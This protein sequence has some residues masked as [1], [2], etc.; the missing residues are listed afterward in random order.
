[1]KTLLLGLLLCFPFLLN[2]QTL[3]APVLISPAHLATNQPSTLTLKWYSVTGA[4][5]YMVEVIKSG[6]NTPFISDTAWTDTTRLLTNLSGGMHYWRIKAKRLNPYQTSEWSAYRVF[7]VASTGGQTLATPVLVSPSSGSNFQVKGTKLSWKTV[8]GATFYKVKVATDAAMNNLVFADSNV[9]VTSRVIPNLNF[10]TT[11]YWNVRAANATSQSA[12]SAT[13]SLTTRPD[14]P[15][16]V[17]THPRLWFTQADLPRLRGWAVAGNPIY[18]A[19]KTALTSANNTYTTKFY[20]GGQANPNWPD[21]GGVTWPAY[22]TEA[23]AEFFAFNSLID[24]NPANRILYAQRA[25]NLLMYIIDAAILGPALGVPFRDPYFANKDRMN[26]WGETYALTVDWIYDAKDANNNPILTAEDK[27]K[28]RTVFMRWCSEQLN[29]YNHPTPIGIMND[30]QLL[31]DRHALNNYYSGHSRSLIMLSLALDPS[32]DPVLD[33]VLPEDALGNSLRSY[34]FNAT[35]AWLYQQYSQYELASIVAND[36]GISPNYPDLS[37]GSG[38][39]SVE[40]S[41]YGGSIGAVSGGLLA[42]KTAGWSNPAVVGPQAKLITSDYWKRYMNGMMHSA[43]PVGKVNQGAAW[44]GPIYPLAC[45]GESIRTWSTPNLIHAMGTTGLLAEI[46]GDQNQL[47]KARWYARNIIEGSAEKLTSRVSGI[48][49]NNAASH[50]ILYYLLLNPSGSNPADPRPTIATTFVDPARPRVLARTDWSANATWFDWQCP[51]ITLDHQLGDA[52]QFELYRKGEWLIK[53]RSGYGNDQLAYTSEFHNT[54]ALQNDVPANLAWFETVT[55]QRGGQ[56]ILGQNAG[57]PSSITSVG[58]NFVY[59]TG[60]ATSLY[61]RPQSSP[62]NSATD[63][64]YAVR[65]IVWLKP[66]HVI[67]YDRAKSKTANRFK[68]FFLQ[69]TA[70]PVIS[71]KNATVSTPGGQKLYLSNLLPAGSVLTTSVSED[72]NAVSALDPTHDEIKIEDTSN[73]T[74]VRFLNVIQGADGGTAKDVP[75]LVQSTDGTLFEGA[76]VKNL[77]VMFPNLWGAPFTF[78]TYTIPGTVNGQIVT[79]LTPNA[80]YNVSTTPN[81]SNVSV[82]ITPGGQLMADA[83]GVLLIGNTNLGLVAAPHNSPIAAELALRTSPNPF[84]E[85]MTIQYELP[86]ASQVS[87]RVLDI[88]GNTVAVLAKNE[89]QAAGQQALL[90]S[91]YNLPAG[92]Y[93]CE[94]TAGTLRSVQRIVKQ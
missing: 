47:D 1:M 22:A 54:L 7:T 72:F 56:W 10:N 71:G 43:A 44:M 66:D 48:W 46:L 28:I 33:P 32:D 90:F 14:N 50:S 83:G 69:F 3:A 19:L 42:L 73:P 26:A 58:S 94:L 6:Q 24:P 30:K 64:L 80:S 37:N 17:G 76:V 27:T 12:Y 5:Q 67:V 88:F 86:E 31:T 35:G 2:A 51:W 38:G 36:Y 75:T 20:P 78:T 87:L 62:A 82:T 25:R 70:A 21:D 9:A 63:I 8:S 39:L 61:N 81:G 11:Y 84:S 15:N 41:L 89:M 18:T 65:S 68:R 57:D 77:A 16:A 60:D 45:Y 23:Y 29:A 79:G 52:N 91:D 55:S 40:S 53:E 92:V 74:D 13:W 93:F 85:S 49:G 4:N 59:A 34:L